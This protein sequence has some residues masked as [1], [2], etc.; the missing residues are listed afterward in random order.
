[1][2]RHALV[3]L[4]GLTLAAAGCSFSYS[5]KSLS[6]SSASSSESSAS[7]AGSRDADYQNDVRDYTAAYVKSGGQYESF[8]SE[9][10]A[11]AK[12]RGITD[13]ENNQSTWLGVG[14]GLKRG[15]VTGVA[16][17]TYQQNLTGLEAKKMKWV[18]TGYDSIK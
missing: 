5:S 7:S 14:Q 16:Y 17:S 18:Q 11:I 1:M 10:A 8:Q 3:L 6:D 12:R 9:L 15:G 13:W 2:R 4:L